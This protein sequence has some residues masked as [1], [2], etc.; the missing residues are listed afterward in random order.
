MLA[1]LKESEV[2]A[3]G[4]ELSGEARVIQLWWMERQKMK[5]RIPSE[6]VLVYLIDDSICNDTM[7]YIEMRKNLILLTASN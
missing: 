4:Q 5:K 7:P 2:L 6:S 1:N 3:A